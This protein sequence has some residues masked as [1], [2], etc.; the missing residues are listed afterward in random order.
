MEIKSRLTIRQDLM[1]AFL[2]MRS[3]ADPLLFK[4]VKLLLEALKGKGWQTCPLDEGQ[5][6][7]ELAPLGL[8]D[9]ELLPLADLQPRGRSAQEALLILMQEAEA[10]KTQLMTKD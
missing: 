3:E 6:L 8:L 5:V 4:G 1:I 7:E 2:R 9:L 10:H